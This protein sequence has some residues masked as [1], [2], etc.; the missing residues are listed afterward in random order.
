MSKCNLPPIFRTL[1]TIFAQ[2]PAQSPNR[3]NKSFSKASDN[4]QLRTLEWGEHL[5]CE[6]L[7]VITRA[8]DVQQDSRFVQLAP[9]YSFFCCK[10]PYETIFRESYLRL[11]SGDV[12]LRSF[13]P[14]TR[15][16]GL[17]CPLGLCKIAPR[18]LKIRGKLHLLI[19]NVLW[20]VKQFDE[21]SLCIC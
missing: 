4:W 17:L 11:S 13:P 16:K 2:T 9:W 15:E 3:H 20:C 6:I 5:K 18:G 1:S 12:I 19:W 7:S 10:P 21:I 8:T 14:E